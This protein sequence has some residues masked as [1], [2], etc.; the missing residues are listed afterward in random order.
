MLTFIAGTKKI[1][2]FEASITVL[3]KSFAEPLAMFSSMFAV[4]GATSIK[5]AHLD[6]AMWSISISSFKS[7]LF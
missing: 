7:N 1:F 3:I 6:K 2:L 5:S 4:A